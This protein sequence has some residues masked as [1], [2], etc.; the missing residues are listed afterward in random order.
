MSFVIR[1]LLIAILTFFVVLCA[2]KNFWQKP[3]HVFGGCLS[4]F[5]FSALVILL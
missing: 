4:F 5:V 3:K 1:F 2:P